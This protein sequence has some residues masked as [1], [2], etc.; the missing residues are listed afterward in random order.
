MAGQTLATLIVLGYQIGTTDDGSATPQI[1]YTE[2]PHEKYLLSNGYIPRPLDLEG[3]EVPE[4]LNQ[5]VERLAENAHNV[6]ASARIQQGWTY[7]K[8]NV[9]PHCTCAL[10]YLFVVIHTSNN[11]IKLIN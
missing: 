10:L 2:L 5:L 4:C 9:S 8:S 6:W 7:G 3:V 11:K 1:S